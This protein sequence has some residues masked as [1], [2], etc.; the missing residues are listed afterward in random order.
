MDDYASKF[1]E[2]RMKVDQNNIILAKHMILK[3][4]QRLKS[5][6]ISIIYA[7]NSVI[8]DVAITTI[9]NIEGRLVMTNKNK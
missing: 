7:R 8:L 1:F 4:V 6:I 2:L 9:R 3:F 5:Q